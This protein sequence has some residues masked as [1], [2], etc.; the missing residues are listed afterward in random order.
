M[1]D[2]GDEDCPERHCM[3]S[4]LLY[5]E[6]AFPLEILERV[7]APMAAEG[8]STCRRW[9]TRPKIKRS[10]NVLTAWRVVWLRRV[11]P[12]LGKRGRPAAEGWWL[13]FVVDV[14]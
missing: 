7:V 10:D 14:V 8:G 13:G 12:I 6:S 9:T 3:E 1:F 4:G 11:S 5:G 2:L